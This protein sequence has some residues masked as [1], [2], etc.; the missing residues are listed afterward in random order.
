MTIRELI[1]LLSLASD[2]DSQ[3]LVRGPGGDWH[4][5]AIIDDVTSEPQRDDPATRVAYIELA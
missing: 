2:Q 4:H 5:G 3:V 1:E